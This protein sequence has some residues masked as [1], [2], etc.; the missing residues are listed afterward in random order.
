M[1]AVQEGGIEWITWHDLR[2]TFASRL[3][4]SSATEETIAALM[5]HS[6][7]ALVKRY[8]HFSPSYLQ[9][10][11]EWVS[12]FGRATNSAER[13]PQE[14]PIS[15]L[16]VTETRIAGDQEKVDVA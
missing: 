11:V 6:S 3:A 16:T 5:R 2:H 15:I 14:D 1:P 8:A 12:S 7:S 9:E 13:A 4:M 10:A